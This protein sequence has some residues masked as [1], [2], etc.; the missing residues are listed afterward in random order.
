MATTVNLNTADSTLNSQGESWTSGVAGER[1]TASFIECDSGK[2]E[3]AEAPTASAPSTSF[4]G[5][6]LNQG[7]SQNIATVA[8]STTIWVRARSRDALAVVTPGAAA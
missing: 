1:T 3:Y 2:I 4:R 8:A 6:L 7:E 5:H